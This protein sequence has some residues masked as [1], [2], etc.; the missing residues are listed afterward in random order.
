MLNKLLS[1]NLDGAT[2]GERGVAGGLNALSR[3]LKRVVELFI[4]YQ[5]IPLNLW[6]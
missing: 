2:L 6:G 5:I 3:R 4:F 1:Q